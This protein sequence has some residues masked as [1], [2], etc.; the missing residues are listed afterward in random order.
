MGAEVYV[1]DYARRSDGSAVLIG[2]FLHTL[3]YMNGATLT[4]ADT[5]QNDGF[6][7]GLD[8]SS[9]GQ[10]AVQI[11]STSAVLPIAVRPTPDGG[12]IVIGNVFTNTSS[13]PYAFGNIDTFNTN[14]TTSG[15]IGKID[16]SGGVVWVD[17]LDG[18]SGSGH[19]VNSVAVDPVTGEVFATGQSSGISQTLTTM[20]PMGV[21]TGVNVAMGSGVW[22][23][24]IGTDGLPK[25]QSMWQ[26]GSVP[27]GLHIALGN[28]GTRYLFGSYIGAF[29]AVPLM[30]VPSAAPSNDGF[31]VTLDTNDKPT[32]AFVYGADDRDDYP[33][34]AGFRADGRLV[35]LFESDAITATPTKPFKAGSLVMDPSLFA[36]GKGYVVAELDPSNRNGL[37]GQVIALPTSPFQQTARLTIADDA[38]LLSLMIRQGQTNIGA[39]TFTL[40]GDDSLF[41]TLDPTTGAPTS[42]YMIDGPSTDSAFLVRAGCSDTI[43]GNFQSDLVTFGT[44]TFTPLIPNVILSARSNRLAFTPIP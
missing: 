20:Q 34:D 5:S 33:I 21:T 24:H 42:A 11:S 35:V 38:P 32:A 18:P 30:T 17:K 19:L 22:Y 44:D 9:N 12:S 43:V 1:D 39:K 37:W 40:K 23:A 29:P 25:T 27:P 2:R 36:A 28:D 41:V 13:D 6:V 3:T 7:V 31:L 4:N 16:S 10:W 26:N 14:A 15:F 8:P